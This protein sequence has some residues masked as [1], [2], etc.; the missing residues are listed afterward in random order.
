M[1]EFEH[2]FITE[3][4]KQR[5]LNVINVGERQNLNNRK[6]EILITNYRKQQMQLW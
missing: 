2:P 6:V 5:G 3:Q 4:V 1:S